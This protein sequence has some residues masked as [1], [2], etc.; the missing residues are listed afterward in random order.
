M[1]IIE[2]FTRKLDKV[3]KGEKGFTLIELL[4][5]IAILGILAAVAIPNIVGL[6]NSGDEAA[7]ATELYNVQ[8]AVTAYMFANDGDIPT[9]DGEPGAIDATAIGPHIMGGADAYTALKWGPYDV[10]A[11]G[12]VSRGEVE[13]ET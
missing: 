9:S 1:K 13:E 2:K 10:A 3:R 6:M 11:D 5:V 7:M 12:A 8:V 4:V